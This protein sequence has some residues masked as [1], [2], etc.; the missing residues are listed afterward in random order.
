MDL[1]DVQLGRMTLSE[2]SLKTGSDFQECEYERMDASLNR[3]MQTH[4]SMLDGINDFADVCPC[5]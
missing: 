5:V 2:V 3:F 1:L 4:T